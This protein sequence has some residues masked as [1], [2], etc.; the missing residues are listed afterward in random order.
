MITQKTLFVLPFYNIYE[1]KEIKTKHAQKNAG[2]SSN[3]EE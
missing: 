2:Q 1:A 3:D